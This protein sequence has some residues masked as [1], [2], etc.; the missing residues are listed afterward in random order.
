MKSKDIIKKIIKI[1]IL[2]FVF[3]SGFI[4]ATEIWLLRTWSDLTASEV[5][6]HLTQSLEGTNPQMIVSYIIKYLIPVIVVM[7]IAVIIALYAHKK[8]KAKIVY[9]LY[10]IGALG[11]F[12]L[13]GMLLE[14]KLGFI[15]YIR[16]YIAAT[17][18]SGEDFIGENYVD[19]KDAELTFPEKKRNLIY[20]Y[21]ESVEM[22]FTDK[23]SGGYFDDN[24]IPE[25][26]ELAR[27]GED[28]SGKNDTLEGGVSLSG[29]NWTMGAMFAQTSGLPL[30]VSIGGNAMSKEESFFPDMI[31]LGDILEDEGYHN[32]LLLGSE[33]KFGGRDT[34]F[35]QHGNYE[36]LDYN[37]A[38]K[39]GKIPE[40]YFVWWGYE[41]EKLFTYARE[42][43]TEL[44][45]KD[46]PFNFTLLTVDTHFED[47]W[48]CDLCR[49]EFGD[50][51]YANVFAC[52]SRQTY[53][54][55]RW[56]QQ[57]DFYDNTTVVLVGDHPTMDKNFC[58]AIS[59]DYLRRTYV[60]FINSAAE[61]E[62]DT[63]RSYTTLDM[64]P[65][66]LAAMGVDIEGDRLGL[67]TNL[68]SD[69]K[70]LL[71]ESNVK[72]LDA[73]VGT[74]SAFM[75]RL[76]HIVIT[77][78]TLDNIQKTDIKVKAND[79]GTLDISLPQVRSINV[80]S[81]LKA[82]LEVE[83]KKSGE[84]KKYDMTIKPKENDP[85]KFS[86]KSKT[87]IPESEINNIKVRIYFT[88][89]NINHYKVYEWS[90]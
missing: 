16:S 35:S 86:V 79:S 21:L 30:Q 50:N 47:G 14:K 48:V 77:T 19:P 7:A 73:N 5:I 24:Y 60:S 6:Y 81:L 4:F 42:E 72:E 74:P 13:S 84:V 67:G 41:D 63:D 56:I 59:D 76:S 62:L 38:I 36:L 23:E 70:T 57:Q 68:F 34:Y 28:F 1:L 9:I 89:Q 90:E 71:E 69:K 33:A 82:E 75:T 87:D 26:T 51:Q 85:N 20:I 61:P 32:Y 3:L 46:E 10:F 49:D 43:L 58:K 17:T 65:T 64:F 2:V 83:N 66:T 18:N 39:E 78:K 80:T 27:E 22:T 40:D 25:L 37:W 54:F 44:A 45:K 8:A 88:T 53:D 11:L 15:S 29:T 55:V 52:S 31:S 12:F